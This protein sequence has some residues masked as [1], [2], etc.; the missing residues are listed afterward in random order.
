MAMRIV[1]IE[2]EGPYSYEELKNLKDQQCDYGVYQIYGGHPVYGSSILLYIGKAQQ[3][4]FGVRLG[5]EK[6]NEW[7]QDAARV[8]IYVGRLSGSK[9]PSHELWNE[10]IDL[11]EK[12]LIYAHGPAANS[13]NLNQIPEGCKHIHVLNWGQRRDLV[14]EVS[15]ARWSDTFHVV[16]NYAAYGKHDQETAELPE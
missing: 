4:T 15:G 3:Q 14:P 2:W 8:E 11:V 7:N 5:Q 10:E 9:T 13:S 16:K 12:L 1:H 6:W